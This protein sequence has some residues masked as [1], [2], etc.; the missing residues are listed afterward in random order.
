MQSEHK[1]IF[2]AH[3]NYIL[4]TDTGMYKNHEQMDVQSILIIPFLRR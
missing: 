2:D 3:K 1:N 4:E